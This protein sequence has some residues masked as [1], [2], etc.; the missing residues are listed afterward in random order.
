MIC[1]FVTLMPSAT[2]KLHAGAR[3]VVLWHYQCRSSRG[4]PIMPQSFYRL[5]G[6]SGPQPKTP[7]RIWAPCSASSQTTP[8]NANNHSRRTGLRK[9][10][11][12]HCEGGC[13]EAGKRCFS[14]SLQ[15]QGIFLI[16]S[17]KGSR[18]LYLKFLVPATNNY[19]DL[20]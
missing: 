2:S 19:A 18:T 13:P 10:I 7:S 20:W 4:Y 12:V 9:T 16:P 1:Y 8:W 15:W 11:L 5:G 14:N 3:C 6:L 17:L